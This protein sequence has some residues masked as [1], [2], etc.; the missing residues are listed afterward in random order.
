MIYLFIKM[1][2][3]EYYSKALT[4]NLLKKNHDAH[5][6]IKLSKQYICN[7]VERLQY[8][9]LFVKILIDLSYNKK[10]YK[11]L[12]KISLS[13]YDW[14]ITNDSLDQLSPL[15]ESINQY[16]VK[17][18]KLNCPTPENYHISSPSIITFNNG[19]R[20]NLRAINYIYTKDGDYISRD[21][22]G[23]VRTKNY[24]IDLDLNFNIHN[25]FEIKEAINFPVYPCHVMGMEDVRL[26]GNHFLC[27][28]LDATKD[29][30][31]KM[32]LGIVDY[33]D[34]TSCLDMIGGH[35]DFN[36]MK[37]LDYNNMGTEKNWLPLYDGEQC[38]IIYSFEPFVVYDLNMQTGE[39]SPYINKKINNYNL[40]SFRGSAV[41]IQYKN[42]WLCSVHQVYYHKKRKY[43]HRLVWMSKDFEEIKYSK[44][45][46]FDKIG[47]EF[48]LGINLHPD[49][50]I[51]TY[52]IDDNHG[53]LTIIDYDTIDN[54][55]N[56]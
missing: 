44:M 1:S 21:S 5:E 9:Q 47:V 52:S 46:Y 54:M 10:A 41:P 13:N 45:F 24:I 28:R 50:L 38:R 36:V 32:C 49:G 55:L 29:H 40:K 20:C 7:E 6:S 34:T 43:F 37:I 2:F 12:E 48:N 35:D 53:T 23:I 25:M 56:L 33:S 22:D 3:V 15:I 14:N 18:L 51:F 27:T 26:F 11:I 39:L 16:S 8:Y 4:Y 42:G 19:Y 17:K 31:P 30:H